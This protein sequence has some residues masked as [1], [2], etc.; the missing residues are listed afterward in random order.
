QRTVVL[1][2][3]FQALSGVITS[4]FTQVQHNTADAIGGELIEDPLVRQFLSS[5]DVG[6]S[7]RLWWWISGGA[8]LHVAHHLLPQLSF[9]EAPGATLRLRKHLD[10]VGVAFPAYPN[11]RRALSAHRALLR[12]LAV[13]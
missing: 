13:S 5:S 1:F 2:L 6:S 4:I 3:I 11:M 10:E 12:H 8:T 7:R 9:L